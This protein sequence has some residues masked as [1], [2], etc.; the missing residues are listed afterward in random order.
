MLNNQSEE[1]KQIRANLLNMY[2]QEMVGNQERKQSEVF[3]LLI[4]KQQIILEE[5]KYLERANVQYEEERVKKQSQKTVLAN[6]RMEE[7]QSFLNNKM[8]NKMK[9]RLPQV[10]Q[11]SSGQESKFKLI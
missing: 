5:R 10:I 6:Q 9:N 8:N 7:Y 2:K 11:N 1:N 4:K 3:F